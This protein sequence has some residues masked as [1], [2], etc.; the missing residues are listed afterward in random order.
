MFNAFRKEKIVI[1]L[2]RRY[3]NLSDLKKAIVKHF[4]E[5]G[6]SCEIVDQHTIKVED[7]KYTVFEKTISMYGVPTQ[8]VVLKEV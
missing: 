3:Y 8:R 2:D 4:G 6:K 5:K 7:K 1:R